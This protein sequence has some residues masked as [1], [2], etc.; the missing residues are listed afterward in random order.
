[1]AERPHPPSPPWYGAIASLAM[2]VAVL[3]LL[4]YTLLDWPWQQ[5]FG[6]WNY[7]VTLVLSA[8]PG[9]LLQHWHGDPRRHEP[10]AAT[11]RA[12]G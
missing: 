11:G 2:L 9:Q 6:A 5:S 8:V 3:W 10:P 4:A 7:L 1:M 12:D